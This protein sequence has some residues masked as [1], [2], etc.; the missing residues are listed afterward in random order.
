MYKSKIS[1]RFDSF[2]IYLE[3][4]EHRDYP[5]L[6]LIL[7]SNVHRQLLVLVP[8]TDSFEVK[9]IAYERQLFSRYQAAEDGLI[10]YSHVFGGDWL[11]M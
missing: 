5:P 8:A 1:M 7:P 2:G 9:T 6:R 11:V 10:R 4:V 3:A